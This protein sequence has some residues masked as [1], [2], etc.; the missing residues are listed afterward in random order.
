MWTKSVEGLFHKVVNRKYRQWKPALLPRLAEGDILRPNH[1]S[2]KPWVLKPTYKK[3][4]LVALELR[5]ITFQKIKRNVKYWKNFPLIF[6]QFS[7]F[8]PN[9]RPTLKKLIK[10]WIFIVHEINGLPTHLRVYS[11]TIFEFFSIMRRKISTYFKLGFNFF[12]K[13]LIIMK[14]KY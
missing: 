6:F 1:P 9:N 3:I 13:C 4:L 8:L 5:D 7:R 11:K 2:K 14:T 10:W 12:F